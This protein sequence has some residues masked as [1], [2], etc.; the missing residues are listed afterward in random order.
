MTDKASNQKFQNDSKP[1][2]PQ[3]ISN[4]AGFVGAPGPKAD[5]K[6]TIT[7]GSLCPDMSIPHFS[8]EKSWDRGYVQFT[9]GSTGKPKVGDLDPLAFSYPSC[10]FCILFFRVDKCNSP[11]N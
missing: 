7:T 2:T 8:T 5:F 3:E 1:V 4:S 10:L 6:K 9:S 11:K